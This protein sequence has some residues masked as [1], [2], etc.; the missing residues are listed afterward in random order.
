M[1]VP[2]FEYEVVRPLSK[3]GLTHSFWDIHLDT[4]IFTWIA[5]LSLVAIIIAGHY[6]LPK[7]L[8]SFSL[9][10]EQ[11][12]MVFVNLCRES[13][14]FF[15]YS[16]FAFIASL[17][18]FVF[19]CNLVG[20]LPFVE[21][22]TRD[23]NTALA[24]GICGF[25][26]VQY[27]AIR[28]GGIGE[29]VKE[30][31]QPFFLLFPINFIGEFAKVAS[32]SFRLFGNVLGGSIVLYILVDALSKYKEYFM[33]YAV[34]VLVGTWLLKKFVNMSNYPML[35]QILVVL[36]MMLFAVAGAQVF[37]G[38]FEAVIQAFVLTMLV[39]TYLSIAV[40]GE[41]GDEEEFADLVASSEDES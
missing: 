15:R 30:Y 38:A 5:M 36:Q 1:K 7:K 12:I 16:Y 29:Y 31:F 41:E 39:T 14:G 3:I 23:L 24:C 35:H 18:I 9:L 10:L 34:T 6:F 32:M 21:E 37:F 25:F 20:S 17:F 11:G 8:N 27:Q 33:G 2:V 40:Q 26:Y 28:H 4:L 13:F 19:F 22:P